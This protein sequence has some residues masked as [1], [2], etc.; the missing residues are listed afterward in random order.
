MSD[1]EFAHLDAAY[2]LGALGQEERRAYEKHLDECAACGRAVREMA[3]MPAL[4]AQVDESVFLSDKD[5]DEE[6][7]PATLLPGL[8]REVRHT[9]RRRIAWAGAAA[10]AA[11]IAIGGAVVWTQYAG[12]GSDDEVAVAPAVTSV[13]MR[14]VGQ[15]AV[16]ASIVMEDV[17][18]GT[19]LELT[20]SYVEAGDSYSPEE[21]PSYTLAVQTRDGEW[22][23]VATWKAVQGRTITVPAATAAATDDIASVEVRTLAGTPVLELES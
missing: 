11:V 10:A 4:L 19:K 3:G 13:P 15:S 9:R 16:R 6:P 2:V 14:Q 7:V 1:D 22:Q 21:T 20:C 18:W 23:Q 17:A 8:L 5:K 12:P